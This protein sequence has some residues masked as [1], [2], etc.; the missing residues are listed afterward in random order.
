MNEEKKEKDKMKMLL[1][2]WIHNQNVIG[3]E[4]M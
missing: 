4:L 1:I 2:Q 3:N